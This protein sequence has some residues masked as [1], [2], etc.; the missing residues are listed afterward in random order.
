M[1][2]QKEKI[3]QLQINHDAHPKKINS[4]LF[5]NGGQILILD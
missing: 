3:L 5:L 4:N 1:Y 2:K